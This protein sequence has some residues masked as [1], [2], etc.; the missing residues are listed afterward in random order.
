MLGWALAPLPPTHT[1]VVGIVGAVSALVIVS[2][3]VAYY[4]GCRVSS[5]KCSFPPSSSSRYA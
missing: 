1:T 2:V 3:V 5:N 4:G